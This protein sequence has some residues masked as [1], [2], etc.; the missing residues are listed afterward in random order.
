MPLS[1]GSC[2]CGIPN[3]PKQKKHGDKVPP[4]RYP[5][6]VALR[7]RNDPKNK[8]GESIQIRAANDPS[9]F[10]ITDRAPTRAF[11]WLKA[12]SSAFTFKT[13]A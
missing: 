13:A 10:K 2:S 12:P 6:I 8:T 5:W 1:S 7:I 11:S 4:H 9:V 3:K